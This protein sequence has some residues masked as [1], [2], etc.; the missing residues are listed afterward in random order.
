MSIILSRANEIAIF[1]G[2]LHLQPLLLAILVVKCSPIRTKT[3]AET[4]NL[5]MTE[6][7]VAPF[8]GYNCS[9]LLGVMLLWSRWNDHDRK[10]GCGFVRKLLEVPLPPTLLQYQMPGDQHSN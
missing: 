10:Q 5:R 7:L 4:D 1:K 9:L 6:D 3:C 2:A 8:L